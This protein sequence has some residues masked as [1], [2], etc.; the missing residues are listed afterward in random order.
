MVQKSDVGFSDAKSALIQALQA[1]QRGDLQLYHEARD[2]PEKNQLMRGI[3]GIDDVLAM[4]KS[5]QGGV[6]GANYESS[7]HHDGSGN[8][9][10]V[11]KHIRWSG[12]DWYV[13]WF[14]SEEQ[15]LWFISVHQ[16][17]TTKNK[18]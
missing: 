17:T 12:G 8:I 6:N 14:F 13:K 10:H 3:V 1:V 11:L 2:D 4:A 9:V 18:T 5:A 15:D 16:K 7:P